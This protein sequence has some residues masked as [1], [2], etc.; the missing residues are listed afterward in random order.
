VAREP[1]PYQRGPGP[2][3]RRRSRTCC[4]T[5]YFQPRFI[6]DRNQREIRELTRYRQCLIEERARDETAL[7]GA[8]ITLGSVVSNGLGV[9][10]TRLVQALADG[11]TDPEHVA[12]LADER[13]R[14]T[15]AKLERALQ[16][17]MGAHRPFLWRQQLRHLM[18][19][20]RPNTDWDADGEA[21]CAPFEAVRELLDSLPGVGRR[22]AEVILVEIGPT[23][24]ACPSP[25]ALAQGV[26]LVTG[27]YESAGKRLA[28]RTIPG[29][30]SLRAALVE[31]APAAGWT[32][33]PDRGPNIGGRPGPTARNAPRS[34]S[35]T[36]SWW[37]SGTS[38]SASNFTP[39]WGSTTSTGGTRTKCHARRSNASKA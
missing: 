24:T 19:L 13:L 17:L 7:E 33:A 6:P 32:K 14:A 35:P 16:G 27:N 34:S 39:I 23:V 18:A 31:A 11:I 36:A 38:S 3:N 26:G 1:R 29:N 15:P 12:A 10:R 8:N 37:P 21:R 22:P 28:R 25:G 5:G 2:Q 4:S 20:D 9:S 30:Q